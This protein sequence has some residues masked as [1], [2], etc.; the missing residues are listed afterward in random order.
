M[1]A[2]VVWREPADQAGGGVTIDT[3]IGGFVRYCRH[4][5]GL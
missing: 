5:S 2:A 4:R 1:V 3:P